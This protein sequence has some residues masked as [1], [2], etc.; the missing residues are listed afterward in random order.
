MREEIPIDFANNQSGH[1]DTVFNFP[2]PEIVKLRGERV[3][4]HFAG[5]ARKG[6]DKPTIEEKRAQCRSNPIIETLA[7]TNATTSWRYIGEGT[8][9]R[10]YYKKDHTF[11]SSQYYHW[12]W[13][14]DAPN[15]RL[16][17]RYSS[18]EAGR[19]VLALCH[20]SYEVMRLV[21][22]QAEATPPPTV[23]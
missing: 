13:L 7:N 10:L 5:H 19:M 20:L 6:G 11:D 4:M 1:T 22:V 2:I 9:R 18:D 15:K 17:V 8:S 21:P 23:E 16:R 3:R 14:F 12:S